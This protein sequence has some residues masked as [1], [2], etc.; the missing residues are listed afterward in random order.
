M[1]KSPKKKSSCHFNVL[2]NKLNNKTERDILFRRS[3]PVWGNF[4]S[5]PLGENGR[6]RQG[7][8]Y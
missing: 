5:T 4:G 2:L 6:S 7:A 8:K 3:P 1:N